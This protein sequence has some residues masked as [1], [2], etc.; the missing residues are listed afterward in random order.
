VANYFPQ[1][2]PSGN[3][4]DC[5]DRESPCD[6]CAPPCP[7]T[8]H[9][10]TVDFSWSVS[11][12]LDYGPAEGVD[13]PPDPKAGDFVTKTG[14]VTGKE[15]CCTNGACPGS[16]QAC[17]SLDGDGYFTQGWAPGG[18][19]DCGVT[20]GQQVSP[21]TL[22]RGG[23]NNLTP[24]LRLAHFAADALY[25]GSAIGWW[26]GASLEAIVANETIG[27]YTST[28]VNVTFVTDDYCTEPVLSSI[29]Y[30]GADDSIFESTVPFSFNLN[31]TTGSCP[32]E[33]TCTTNSADDPPT[34]TDHT[35][36]ASIDGI[37]YPCE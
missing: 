20:V 17:D 34:T 8:L 29:I 25:E 22:P 24:G 21:N 18:L 26:L 1:A 23:S 33:P 12:C 10:C 5:P 28:G 31:R 6:P 7:P 14:S 37:F 15:L 3:C 30:L 16:T 27:D 4:C 19:D 2:D 11:Y 32:D 35:M 13:P 36:I 9:P